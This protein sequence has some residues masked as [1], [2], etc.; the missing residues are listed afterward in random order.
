MLDG[1]EDLQPLPLSALPVERPAGLPNVTLG[2]NGQ[3]EAAEPDPASLELEN[4]HL[5]SNHRG[6]VSEGMQP[7][8]TSVSHLKRETS[9]VPL[10]MQTLSMTCQDSSA[11]TMQ[12]ACFALWQ[13]YCQL[14]KTCLPL[15]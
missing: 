14:I 15:I 13:P 6:T 8:T 3:D 2:L 5:L 12:Q 7:V 1:R 9:H 10:L 11:A 4:R